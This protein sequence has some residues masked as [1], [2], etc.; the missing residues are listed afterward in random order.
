MRKASNTIVETLS[1]HAKFKSRGVWSLDSPELRPAL[2]ATICRV[3]VR[4]WEGN[5][6]LAAAG[7]VLCPGESRRQ[8]PAI[9]HTARR[10]TAAPSAA[11]TQL[12]WADLER[13]VSAWRSGSPVGGELDDWQDGGHW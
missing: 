12:R 10:L 6:R 7:Q 8:K 9:C 5:S 1:E 4:T 2:P 11:A 3:E 13:V